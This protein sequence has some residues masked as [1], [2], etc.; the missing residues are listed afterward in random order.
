MDAQKVAINK[1]S[2]FK[3]TRDELEHIAH[4]SYMAEEEFGKFQTKLPIDKDWVEEE[5]TK[6]G[7]EEYSVEESESEKFSRTS[8]ATSGPDSQQQSVDMTINPIQNILPFDATDNM[9]LDDKNVLTKDME[10]E[11]DITNDRISFDDD[12]IPAHL[13]TLSPSADITSKIFDKTEKNLLSV[14]KMEHINTNV[15]SNVEQEMDAQKV[16]INKESEFKLTRDELEHIAHVSYMAEE[17][18]GKFQT[19]L[20]IDKD[21]VEEEGTKSGY[22]EYSV[23]ESESEK[24]SRTSSATSGPDSQQ[25]SVDMTINPIQNI[26]PFDATDNMTLDDKNVLTKDMEHEMDITNDRI[27]FDDDSIPAHLLTLSPSADTSK[28]FDKT[29]KICYQWNISTQMLLAM[30]NKKWMLKKLP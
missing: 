28:I 19:K 14:E 29:E 30:L 1:E 17:E 13:L 10:H 21:W 24:F 22:E 23:E 7:Y 20:P 9:T 5:G 27:S 4:V 25:Q 15:I 2:E 18:F 11:M 6:S 16:A 12:S 3:L 8:S 26:L